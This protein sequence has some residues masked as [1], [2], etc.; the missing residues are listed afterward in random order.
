[1]SRILLLIAVIFLIWYGLRWW[2]QQAP[3]QRSKS[4][5]TYALWGSAAVL[6]LLFLTGRAHWI[7]AAIGALLP[8]AKSVLPYLQRLIPYAFQWRQQKQQQGQLTGEWVKLNVNPLSGR[9]N[10]SVLKGELKD[11]SLSDLSESDLKVL[12]KACLTEDMKSAQ[13]LAAF[14]QQT[15]GQQWQERFADVLNAH[16]SQGGQSR[17]QSSGASFD[18]H[19]GPLSEQE[20]YEI[21]GVDEHA[22]KDEIIKAYKSLMQKVHPDRGGSDYLTRLVS[23]AKELLLKKF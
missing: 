7:T 15:Y 19:S 11:R 2:K 4:L 10:G 16:Q 17:G 18:H 20:A 6:I 5:W 14:L 1:M 8:L 22:S 21:L 3:K 13:L 23:E 9:L 12:L